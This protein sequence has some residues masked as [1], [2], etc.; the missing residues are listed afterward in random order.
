MTYAVA[1]CP[2]GRRVAACPLEEGELGLSKRT[3]RW[4]HRQPDHFRI[5]ELE[6]TVVATEYCPDCCIAAGGKDEVVVR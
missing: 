2:H 6:A 3:T 1:I 4:I 5:D